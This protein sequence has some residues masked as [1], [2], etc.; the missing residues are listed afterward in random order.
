MMADLTKDRVIVKN[1]RVLGL[2]EGV[3][4][5]DIWEAKERFRGIGSLLGYS[6]TAISISRLGVLGFKTKVRK[7]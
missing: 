3:D 7:A 2:W 6:I 4:K 5:G 1:L